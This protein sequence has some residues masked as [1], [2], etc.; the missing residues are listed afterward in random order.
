MTRE[1]ILVFC[2][3]ASAIVLFSI[4]ANAAA[5]DPAGVIFSGALAAVSFVPETE[6]TIFRACP[7]GLAS[8]LGAGR[9]ASNSSRKMCS[10]AHVEGLDK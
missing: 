4:S 9:S 10:R 7:A 8:S 3:L 1:I 5:A 2:V 6:S